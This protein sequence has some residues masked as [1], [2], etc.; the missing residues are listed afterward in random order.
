[1]IVSHQ[2]LSPDVKSVLSDIEITGESVPGIIHLLDPKNAHGWDGLS[3]NMTNLC[4]VG[5]SKPLYL[6]HM[7]CEETG[8]FPSI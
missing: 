6:M 5:I 3:I 4:Y 7:E 8:W 1:M 2:T